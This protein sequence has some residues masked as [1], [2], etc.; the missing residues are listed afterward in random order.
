MTPWVV[1]PG[2]FFG[3]PRKYHGGPPTPTTFFINLKKNFKKS[4]EKD[5]FSRAGGQ[6]VGLWTALFWHE[7]AIWPRGVQKYPP[8]CSQAVYHPEMPTAHMREAVYNTAKRRKQG[9]ISQNSSTS[10]GVNSKV[11]KRYVWAL[12]KYVSY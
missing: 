2:A 1:Q 7:N 10:F 8:P 11:P 12:P 6:F 4:G 5:F 3:V 9:Y